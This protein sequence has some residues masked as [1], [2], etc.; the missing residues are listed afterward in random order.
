MGSASCEHMAANLAG[1]I[2]SHYGCEVA[3]T[4]SE[5]GECGARVSL[6]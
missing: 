6:P 5:D 3:V 1:A 2:L 4:V